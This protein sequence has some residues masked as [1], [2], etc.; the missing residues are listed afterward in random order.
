[1]NIAKVQQEMLKAVLKN[2]QA[3]AHILL[4]DEYKGEDVVMC[5]PDCRV[6]YIFPTELLRVNLHDTRVL[7]TYNLHSIIKPANLLTGTDDYRLGGTARRYKRAEDWIADDVYV[8][9]G[10]LKLFD[11]PVLYQDPTHQYSII[12]VVERPWE[13]DGDKLVG[14]VLPVKVETET[15]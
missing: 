7:P 5:T 15:N 1:M 10:L 3:A 8:D 6:G 11:Q 13:D 12:A 14:F 4:E 9:Q 2:P